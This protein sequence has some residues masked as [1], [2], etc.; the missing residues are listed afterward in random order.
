[1]GQ[2]SG[3]LIVLHRKGFAVINPDQTP[4]PIED[5]ALIGDCLTAALVSRA[6][7]IDWLCLPRFDSA[8]CF[9]ALLGTRRN[10]HWLISPTDPA[11]RIT[12]RYLDGSMVLET[13]FETA[14]GSVAL[15]DFMPIG[16]NA[17]SLIRLVEGRRGKVAMRLELALR[18]DYGASIPWVTRLP[19]RGGFV[20]IA[21]PDLVVLR[22]KIPLHGHAMT[23]IAS[24][25]VTEGETI[26]FVLSHGPSH[27]PLPAPLDAAAELQSTSAFWTEWSGR[28]TYR[29]NWQEAVRRS[30]ITLKGLTYA[31]TGGIAAAATTSLPEQ[32]GGSRNWD[33]RYCWLRDATL[34]LYAMMNAG[35]YEEAQAWRD[36]LHRSIAGSADQIQ[37]MYGL[38]GERRLA[39]W[40]VPWLPGYQ[41]ASPVRIGNAASA[42]IQLDVYGEVVNALHQARAC[43]LKTPRSAWSMQR[44]MVDHLA[45]IWDQPD[46]GIWEVRGGAKHFTYSK[47]MCWVALDRAVRDAERH[48]LAAPVEQWRKLRDEIHASVCAQG[49]NE[50]KNS[51]TQS[52]GSPH[53]DASLLLLPLVGFLPPED[54]RMRGT[55]AAIERELVEDGFV[56]RYRTDNNPSDGLPPGE[57][58]FLACSFW[59][60]DNMRMQRRDREARDLFDRLL[61]LRNDVGLLAEE[62]DPC[63]QRQVGNFPQAFSHVAL[64][65]TA[66]NF[67][68]ARPGGR[69]ETPPQP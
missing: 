66:M 24:F 26:P 54:P 32:L 51:F 2:S 23:T 3:P 40:E 14:D 43:G 21:G 62:Y 56:L 55:L 31:P 48:H 44:G 30:C 33:Y 60:A 50:E 1:M 35:Y 65:G 20:A 9:A 36:W 4:A 63:A 52:F 57:G 6:G 27:L 39:E 5:Y 10:G 11:P 38:S 19:E 12:R 15:I 42:Q 68:S 45:K 61:S 41:G 25:D 34:T 37:I 69:G 53:L 47:V 67:S 64:I 7:S 46:E 17:S 49:F 8:A 18:F 58:V 59:L 16:K 13:L 28:C 22:T 29:G